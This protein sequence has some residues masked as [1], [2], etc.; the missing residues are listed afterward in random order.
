[1]NIYLTDGKNKK[2]ILDYISKKTNLF[3][4]LF[5]IFVIPEIIRND[6]GKIRYKELDAKYA[7]EE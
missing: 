2:E 7:A 6:S 1:M 3:K 5:K 4:N